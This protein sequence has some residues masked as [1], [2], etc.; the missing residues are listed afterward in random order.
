MMAPDRR[1]R[2]ARLRRAC[3]FPEGTPP[4]NAPLPSTKLI[5]YDMGSGFPEIR[6]ANTRRGWMD[7]TSANR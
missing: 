4:M 3:A 1:S 7:A 5:A 6:P 2:A